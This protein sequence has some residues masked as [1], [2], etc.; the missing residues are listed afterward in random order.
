LLSDLRL[1]VNS[2]DQQAIDEALLRIDHDIVSQASA[3][4]NISGKRRKH[5]PASADEADSQPGD[6]TRVPASIG[7]NEDLDLLDEDLLRSKEARE[8]GYVGT[9]ST[10]AWLRSLQ[11][12]VKQADGQPYGLPCGPP[13]THHDSVMKRSE[14]LHERR[15][16]YPAHAMRPETT[17]TTFYLDGESLELDFEVDIHE[18]PPFELA[19]RL[20]DTYLC[21]VHTSFPIMPNTMK[22]Q[23][24]SFFEAV[25]AKNSFRVPDKWLA[26]LNLCFA[27]GS[28]YSFL[29]DQD[30]KTNQKDH[31]IYMTRAVRLLALNDNWGFATAPDLPT[32]QVTGLLSFYYMIIGH[33]SRAWVTIGIAIR[34]ALALGLHLRNEDPTLPGSKKET[35]LRTWWSLHSIECLVSSVIGR[36]C[37]LASED[38][39]V[40]FPHISTDGNFG[41]PSQDAS[42]HASITSRNDRR[43]SSAS[44]TSS[45]IQ[46]S[47]RKPGGP[48]SFLEAHISI[49]VIT[50][51]ILSSLYSPRVGSQPWS[52]IQATIP[53]LLTELEVWRSHVL[54]HGN[55]KISDPFSSAAREREILQLRFYYYSK[56]ILITR[57]CLCRTERRIKDQSDA[58][59]IFNDTTAK[60]CVKAAQDMAD[61]LPEKPHL[62]YIFKNGPWW[63][64]VHDIM[65]SLTVLLLE[66]SYQCTHMLNEK[67]RIVPRTKKLVH[68]LRAMRKTDPSSERA[69]TVVINIIRQSGHQF[70]AHAQ[71]LLSEDR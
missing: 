41:S 62:K 16:K 14:A 29:S 52:Y 20:F 34:L 68:W 49:G 63:T 15:R 28:H 69:Y 23:F 9:N 56:V 54:P 55:V 38:C 26:Q 25:R 47:M 6:E 51:K 5:S 35:L 48:S 43:R 71:D 65:Q 32:I 3:L 45:N 8:T 61:L 50:Q 2:N 19:E 58:S 39:T 60:R 70:Q 42:D 44:A 13:G 21:T 37:V 1:R 12:E 67:A 30:W 57:P 17:E 33:V 24:Y 27:I 22:S 31:L 11:K 36:P 4:P 10:V 46:V 64:L 7:S 40:E 66:L 59:F 53:T 18:L